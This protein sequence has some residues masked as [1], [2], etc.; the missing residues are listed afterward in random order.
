VDQHTYGGEQYLASYGVQST[1]Q[2]FTVAVA[3]DDVIVSG[4]GDDLTFTSPAALDDGSWHFVTA[5]TTG[6]SATVYVDGTA[7]G[8]QNFPSE[9]DTLPPRRGSWSARGSRT[10][11]ATSTVTGRHR[12]LP[13]AL[14]SAQVTAQFAASGLGRPPAPG[15]PSAT[16]GANQATVSW[17]PRRRPIRR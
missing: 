15:A 16:A 12:R 9:L 8:T 11:A 7:I 10:A 4:W 5:T 6:T 3:P 13:T 14:S 1:G 2:G 17:Q